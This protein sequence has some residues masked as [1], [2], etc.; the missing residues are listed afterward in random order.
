MVVDLSVGIMRTATLAGQYYKPRATSSYSTKIGFSASENVR[1][2]I[3]MIEVLFNLEEIG[4][5]DV[6]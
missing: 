5:N 3:S 6:S 2:N 1:T 4:Q